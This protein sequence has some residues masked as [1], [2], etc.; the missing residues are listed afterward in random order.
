MCESAK[1][2]AGL[3]SR[4]ADRHVLASSPFTLADLVCQVH[5]AGGAVSGLPSG[6]LSGLFSSRIDLTY[7]DREGAQ[8]IFSLEPSREPADQS[9]LIGKSETVDGR[10]REITREQ[11]LAFIT[12]A[13]RS[14]P[15]G[16]PDRNGVT[17]CDRL[18]SDPNDPSKRAEGVAIEAVEPEL[19]VE[20]CV[21]AL[22]R[23]PG[24]PRLLF[25]MG[26]ALEAGGVSQDS[27]AY[28]EAAAA[29][30]YAAAHAALGELMSLE[31]ATRSVAITH[32]QK[33]VSNGYSAA[34]ETLD[35]LKAAN[36]VD[37]SKGWPQTGVVSLVCMTIET[38]NGPTGDLLFENFREFGFR[39]DLDR[40]MVRA[41][42]NVRMNDHS[43]FK[44]G[45][46]YKLARRG[47]TFE[48]GAEQGR[49]ELEPNSLKLTYFTRVVAGRIFNLEVLHELESTGECT[50]NLE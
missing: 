39:I 10:V 34:S 49:Y 1:S 27:R 20:A 2:V 28:L 16:R 7:T 30:D 31:E 38:V 32:L 37:I 36:M 26:R 47:F 42:E 6:M 50:Q 12:E 29:K 14:P 24:S 41:T 5:L 33:A 13:T 44:Q 22:E 25:L 11:W 8:R 48:I 19:A 17:E 23:D 4:F 40:S 45:Q 18:V 3:T 46:E 21:A 43:V 9:A 15:T 35:F